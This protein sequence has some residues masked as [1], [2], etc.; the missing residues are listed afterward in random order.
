VKTT[1]ASLLLFTGSI[2]TFAIFGGFVSKNFPPAV[3]QPTAA[4]CQNK[5]E[6]FVIGGHT[7]YK[8]LGHPAI[9]Y[10]SGMTIDADGAPK[11]YHR[12]NNKGLDFLGNAGKP[13]N[14]WALVTDTGKSNGTPIVQ[15]PNDPAPGYYVSATALED[16][17]KKRTEPRRYVDSSNIPYIV[18]PGNSLI[19]KTG[20]RLG[21]FAVVFNSKSGRISNAIFADIGPKAKIGEGSIALAAAL[22]INSS[23]KTGGADGGVMYVVFPNSGNGKPRTIA[24]INNEATKHFNNWGGMTRLKACL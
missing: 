6:L 17:T 10:Q 9:F 20:A 23:P 24:E 1:F 15:G 13:G 21:D 4:N 16:S 5:S 19:K 2:G 8:W 3:A 11:A 14:W 22:G 18:L 7:V 12:D